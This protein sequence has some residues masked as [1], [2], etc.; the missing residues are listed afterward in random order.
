M[1]KIKGRSERA[2]QKLIVPAV[3]REDETSLQFCAFIPEN[4][5]SIERCVRKKFCYTYVAWRSSRDITLLR[6]LREKCDIILWF[7]SIL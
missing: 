2:A 5:V 3:A 6:A 1:P 7:D 4:R